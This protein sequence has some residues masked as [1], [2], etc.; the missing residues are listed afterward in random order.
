[1]PL[2]HSPALKWLYTRDS[3]GSGNIHTPNIGKC[4]K[5]EFGNYVTSHRAIYRVVHDL[6]G[7]SWWA[8]DG[9]A[10]EN[11]LSGNY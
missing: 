10:S 2:G 6:G 7:E 4:N 11:P 3:P 5:M 1:M 9:G 8:I